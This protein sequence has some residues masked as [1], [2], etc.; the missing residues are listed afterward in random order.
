M[1]TSNIAVA[2]GK[3]KYFSDKDWQPVSERR[4]WQTAGILPGEWGRM[5]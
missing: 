4:G 5:V 3:E 2:G 1:N